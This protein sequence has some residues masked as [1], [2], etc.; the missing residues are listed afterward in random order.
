MPELV[1]GGKFIT[2]ED[3]NDSLFAFFTAGLWASIGRPLIYAILG[4]RPA[5]FS[6]TDITR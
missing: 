1:N 4:A 2:G 3:E 5:F 6:E